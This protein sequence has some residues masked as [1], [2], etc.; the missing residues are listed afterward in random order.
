MKLIFNDIGNGLCPYAPHKKPILDSLIGAGI[1]LIGGFAQG[2]QQHTFTQEQQKLQSRLNKDEMAYSNG[3]QRAQQ[4]WLMNS[5]YGAA[6][7]GMKGAGL[8]PAT[9][10]GTSL[11]T[12]SASSPTTGPSGPSAGMPNIDLVASMKGIQ[13]IKNSVKLTDAQT[14]ALDAQADK[15]R[16]D[17]NLKRKDI[18]SYGDRL[19][20]DLANKDAQTKLYGEQSNEAKENA[21]YL[22]QKGGEIQENIKLIQ[23]H[24]RESKANESFTR[25]QEREYK[26]VV[27]AQVKQA[28]A[29]KHWYDTQSSLMVQE[30]LFKWTTMTSEAD[31]QDAQRL[32]NDAMRRLTEKYGDAKEV[33]QII[34]DVTRSFGDV[35]MDFL[36]GSKLGGIGK[37]GKVATA[38]YK[39]AKRVVTKYYD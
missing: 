39:Q 25:A 3:L 33:A 24:V 5:Q 16:A 37:V 10:N 4:E 22:R 30:A 27:D 8:N 11:S 9:A 18:N 36:I 29:A 2:A 35:A 17:A 20:A 38:G 14:D 13:D 34:S 1:N 26:R 31:A 15:D 6:V 28:F 32:L 19:A 12:P 23:Q 21:N 7:S